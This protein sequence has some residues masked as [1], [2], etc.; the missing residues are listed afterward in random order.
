MGFLRQSKDGTTTMNIL[1]GALNDLPERVI[2]LGAFTGKLQQGTGQ[3]QTFREDR[4]NV[5][6][7]VKP[8]NYGAFSSFAPVYDSR[9]SNLSKEESELVMSTYGDEN[10]VQYAD[11]LLE[12]TQ[13]SSYAS[14]LANSLLDYLTSGEH[15]KTLATITESHRQRQE[16]EEIEK[17]FPDNEENPKKY[18]NVK[19]DFDNLKSLSDLGLDVSFLDSMEQE[20]KLFELQKKLQNQLD[21]NSSLIERLHQAQYD[22]LSQPLPPHLSHI[23]KPNLDEIQL[24]NQLT[25]NLAEVAKQLAPAMIAHPQG[26]RKAMGLSTVGLENYIHPRLTLND[27]QTQLMKS[28]RNLSK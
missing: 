10:A 24:A 16:K 3:L 27:N 28:E 17:I 20:V 22:R 7:I 6:K 5:A 1:V 12:F 15:R 11:S 23:S 21:V 18:E 14:G 26:L 4:R 9:Y 25:T 19:I 8:L 13:N 2:S